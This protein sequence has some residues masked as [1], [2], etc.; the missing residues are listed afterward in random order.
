MSVIHIF[1]Y[2]SHYSIREKYIKAAEKYIY[3]A[4]SSA[5]N[6]ITPNSCMEKHTIKAIIM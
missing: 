2:F 5:K 1:L 4:D 3:Q 6:E